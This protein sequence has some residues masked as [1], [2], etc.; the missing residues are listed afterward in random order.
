MG[1]RD[2][3]LDIS[4][5]LG[6]IHANGKNMKGDLEEIKASILAHVA[7][8]LAHE[9]ARERSW[10]STIPVLALLVSVASLLIAC[11]AKL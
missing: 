6:E 4:R 11:A 2:W 10:K 1:D 8:P 5:Q 3:Q 9:A 7:D